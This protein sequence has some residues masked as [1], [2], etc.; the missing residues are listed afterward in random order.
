[1]ASSDGEPAQQSHWERWTDDSGPFYRACVVLYRPFHPDDRGGFRDLGRFATRVDVILV[2]AGGY[3]A[4]RFYAEGLL[5][6]PSGGIEPSLLGITWVVLYVGPIAAYVFL[7]LF[8]LY[9]SFWR[10]H[11]KMEGGRQQ[12]IEELQRATKPAPERDDRPTSSPTPKLTPQPGNLCA[13]LRRGRSS[14]RGCS[15]FSSSTRWRFC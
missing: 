9:H 5:N 15:G 1:M 7:V 11:K 3:V 6:L 10:L 12:R 8:W 2:V 13:T 14:D 4:Y